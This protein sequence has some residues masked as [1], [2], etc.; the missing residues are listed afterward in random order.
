MTI[1]TIPRMALGAAVALLGLVIAL[2]L[3]ASAA[4]A[5]PHDGGGGPYTCTGGNVPSGTYNS[6][7]ITGVCF[8]PVG[9]IT[10][11]G[12]LIIAPGALLDAVTPGDPPT[13]PVVPATVRIG[14]NV[15]VGKGAVLALGCSPNISCS[16]PPGISFDRV[17]GNLTAIGALAVVIH[18]ATIRGSVTIIGGG[19]GAAGGANSGAC[20]AAPIP[21]PWSQAPGLVAG[22]PQYNDVEDAFIGGNLAMVGVQTCWLGSLRNQV[23]GSL[24]YSND[25]TSD[26]DGMEVDNNLMGGSMICLNN[27]PAV[28]FGDAGAAPNLVGGFAAGQCGFDVTV[29]NTGEGEQVTVSEH[30]SVRLGSLKTYVGAHSAKQVASL[31]PATTT[32]GYVITADLKNFKLTGTGLTGTGTTGPQGPTGPGEALLATAYP[33]GSKSFIAYDTCDPGKCSFGGQAGTTTIRFYGTTTARGLT[34]GTFLVTSGGTGNGG[35]STLAGWGTFTSAGQ[36]HGV[37][38]LVEHLRLT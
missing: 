19:G 28:Q 13:G 7:L 15:L 16:N 12:N 36:P 24:S 10:V 9:T 4:S 29:P 26:P 22:G 17:G 23:R 31:P 38:R 30:I 2:V 27:D 32:S 11:R 3:T 18:S 14:G 33:D 20:F 35:L 5:A 25:V 21:A 37:W 6:I 1:R 34:F 8:A